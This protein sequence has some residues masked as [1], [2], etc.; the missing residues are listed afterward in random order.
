MIGGIAVFEGGKERWV[1]VMGQYR[2][3]WIVPRRSRLYRLYGWG[4]RQCADIV[5]LV[6]HKHDC[7]RGSHNH[8]L[9]CFRV[10]AIISLCLARFKDE[11]IKARLQPI[12]CL[13]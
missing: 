6:K 5:E 8:H 12:R 4:R 11:T 9:S 13:F 10:C 3:C 1:K 7:W 2:N